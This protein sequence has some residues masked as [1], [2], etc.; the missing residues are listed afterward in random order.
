MTRVHLGATPPPASALAIATDIINFRAR[1]SKCP[2]AVVEL[3]TPAYVLQLLDPKIDIS[4]G[5]AR[6]P[7]TAPRPAL[8][9]HLAEL[10]GGAK[11]G[12]APSIV[13]V[14]IQSLLH[15][16]KS[17]ADVDAT[18]ALAHLDR[19]KRQDIYS[20]ATRGLSPAVASSLSQDFAQLLQTMCQPVNDSD[21][22]GKMYLL[23]PY[24][25]IISAMLNVQGTV[26]GQSRDRR[27]HV[28]AC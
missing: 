13:A 11:V 1:T 6:P 16:L 7:M 27:G 21:G 17:E 25:A 23:P 10:M 22:N 3:V 20:L 24:G 19:S 9:A 12:P 2:A 28:S 14:A 26:L 4:S 15:K 5:P 8:V 18:V